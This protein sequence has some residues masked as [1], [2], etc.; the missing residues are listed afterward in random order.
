MGNSHSRP[1]SRPENRTEQYT[2]RT[3]KLLSN[4]T[5]P[6]TRK[7]ML[8]VEAKVDELTAGNTALR[9]TARPVTPPVLKWLGNL[10]K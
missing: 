6:R 10:K 5:N 2:V 7:A 1:D 8:M 9:M 3:P 4:A